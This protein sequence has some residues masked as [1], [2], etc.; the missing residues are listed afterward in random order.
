VNLQTTLT[1]PYILFFLNNNN[2]NNKLKLMTTAPRNVFNL[3][4][5]M[6]IPRLMMAALFA[7]SATNKAEGL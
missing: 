3:E 1:V 4:G 2:N 5:K 6:Y 7:V